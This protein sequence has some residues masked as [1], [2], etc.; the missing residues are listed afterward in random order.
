MIAID[1]S[2]ILA[3][4]LEESEAPMFSDIL[5]RKKAIIGASTLLETHIVLASRL[6]AEGLIFLSNLLLEARIEIVPFT[7]HHFQIAREAFSRYGKGQGHKAQLN[8][9]DCLAYAVAKADNIPLLFKGSDFSY[10]DIEAA[11]A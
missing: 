8:F 2:A 11:I 5:S 7:A 1:T 10:T 6:E 4:A 9:G 3:I